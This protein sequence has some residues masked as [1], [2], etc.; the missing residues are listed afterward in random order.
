MAFAITPFTDELIP[1]VHDLNRRLTAGGAPP[2]FRFPEHPTPEWLPKI[3][4]RRIYQE[5]FVLVENGV[6]RGGYG[7]QKQKFLLH[8]HIPPLGFF[9][10]PI[11]QGVGKKSYPPG[12]PS[13]PPYS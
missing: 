8:R 7:F 3:G 10:L 12:A 11:S 5:Y 13:E 9:S 4:D 1:A 2:E 6:A